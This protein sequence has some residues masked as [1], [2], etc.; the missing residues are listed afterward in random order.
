MQGDKPA[1]V[2]TDVTNRLEAL[3]TS[4]DRLVTSEDPGIS[5]AATTAALHLHAAQADLAAPPL[6]EAER[7]APSDEPSASQTA[8]ALADLGALINDALMSL[9]TQQ[10]TAVARMAVHVAE[11]R[12]ALKGP[13]W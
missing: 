8:R 13:S 6:A 2:L 4:V 3:R 11:A 1:D 10:Q 9:P 5:Y 7:P 12:D